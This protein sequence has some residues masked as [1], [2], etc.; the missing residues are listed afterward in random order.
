MVSKR[1]N[2]RKK[3][4]K[5]EKPQPK[6]EANPVNVVEE[7]TK[8]VVAVLKPDLDNK[9]NLINQS[10]NQIGE[11]FYRPWVPFVSTL[12]LFIFGSNWAGAIIPW[13][14]ILLPENCFLMAKNHKQFLEYSSNEIKNPG[15]NEI[16]KIAKS[17]GVWVIIGSVNIRE[18]N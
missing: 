7:I 4:I 8:N 6:E 1:N 3:T 10:V 15:V 13:K 9:I 11:S 17:L 16:K 2:N 18:K 12:F 5:T 14:L